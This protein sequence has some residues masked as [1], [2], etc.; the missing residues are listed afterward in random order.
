M[1]RAAASDWGSI[2]R[3]LIS[4]TRRAYIARTTIAVRSTIASTGMSSV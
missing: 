2:L 4:S 1:S 3:D